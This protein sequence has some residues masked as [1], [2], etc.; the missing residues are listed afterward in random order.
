V[1]QSS[2]PLEIQSGCSASAWDRK[3][4]RGA[5]P[6][7][8]DAPTGVGVFEHGVFATNIDAVFDF[9][10]TEIA[11][12]V[13]SAGILVFLYAF[14]SNIRVYRAIFE[15]GPSVGVASVTNPVQGSAIQDG[16]RFIVQASGNGA[17][18]WG[19][20]VSGS[21]VNLT[22]MWISSIAH[23]VEVPF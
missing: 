5:V 1:T 2:T 18:G 14:S 20:Q 9:S 23:G 8:T 10:Q 4:W 17:S 19:I 12:P 13:V 6:T 11:S 22:N 16:N 15:I 3:W 7:I 21:N